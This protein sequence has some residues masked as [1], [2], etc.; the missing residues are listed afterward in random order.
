MP[1]ILECALQLNELKLRLAEAR[2]AENADVKAA[3]SAAAEFESR[4]G[5]ALVSQIALMLGKS[6]DTEI[7]LSL[8]VTSLHE[9]NRYVF[10]DTSDHRHVLQAWMAESLDNAV[11]AGAATIAIDSE[12]GSGSPHRIEWVLRQGGNAL[13]LAPNNVIAEQ[14]RKQVG[15]RCRVVTLAEAAKFQ[16]HLTT[17]SDSIIYALERYPRQDGIAAEI[18]EQARDHNPE[19]LILYDIGSPQDRRLI[20]PSV[21]VSFR[22]KTVALEHAGSAPAL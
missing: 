19:A 6:G 21:V 3:A 1:T 22:E 4:L 9:R 20:E 15:G 2:N 5:A 16:L 17:L 11:R 12:V 18:L 8:P 13:I 14:V 10:T 7:D